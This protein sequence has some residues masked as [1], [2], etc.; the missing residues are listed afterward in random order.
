MLI[1]IPRVSCCI[2]KRDVYTVFEKLNLG[3][4]RNVELRYNHHNDS[5]LCIIHV[6]HF[7]K[8]GKA[9]HLKKELEEGRHF[10]I[11]HTKEH[12]IPTLWKC[13]PYT[14]DYIKPNM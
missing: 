13:Y 11:V 6:E 8:K 5:Y 7:H 10:T 12:Q 9:P 4:I 3:S 14:E 2:K 1:C